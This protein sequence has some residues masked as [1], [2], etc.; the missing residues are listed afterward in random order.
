VPQSTILVVEDEE[1]LRLTVRRFL[2]H[3]G[4]A[5][6]EA[7]S[8]QQALE[9]YRTSPPDAILLDYLLPDGNALELLPRLR[10]IAASVPVILLTAHASVDLAVRAIKEGAE[11]FLPKPVEFAALAIVLRRALE[12]ERTRKRQLATTSRESRRTVDPFLGTSGAIRRLADDARRVA[13]SQSPVL[14]HGETGTGKSVLARWI[15][16][17]GSRAEEAFVDL[18][19]AGLSRE[20]LETEL[21]G[22]EKGAFTGAVA[23]KPGLLEIAHRGTVFLDEIGDLELAIQPKLLMALEERRFRRVGDVRDRRVDIRL[24]AATHEDLGELV[25][26]K[27]FRADLYYRISTVP[28]VVPPLRERGDDVL[29]LADR[30][31]QEIGTDVGRGGL[32]LSAGARWALASYRW[33]GNIRELRNVLERAVLLSASGILESSDFRF[34]VGPTSP[35]L[36]EYEPMTLAE[37]ERRFVERVLRAENYRVEKAARVLGVSRNTLYLKLKKLGIA[38]GQAATR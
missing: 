28:L 21:F 6:A 3:E 35:A 23:A 34:D 13:A 18:N 9:S 12:K 26:T 29:I 22:H 20:L 8:C 14:I 7:A 37:N 32:E 11:N 30:L 2:Q 27:A 31:L 17:E 24:I 25:R 38:R 16:A 5:V 4:Y 1:V 36:E 19:C 15:H 33:P 10:E